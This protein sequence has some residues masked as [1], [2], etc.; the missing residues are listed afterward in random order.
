MPDLDRD[1]IL[2]HLQGDEDTL[3]GGYPFSRCSDAVRQEIDPAA[4]TASFVIVT[5]GKDVN[6]N[7]HRVQIT[8]SDDGGGFLLDSFGQNPVVFFD[9]GF[10]GVPWPIGR[11]DTPKLSASKATASVTFSQSLPEARV[12]FGLLDEG[13]LNTASVSFLPLKGRLFKP[14]RQKLGEDEFDFRR[15]Q[16]FDFLTNDLLE[17]SVVGVPADPGAVRK[18]LDRGQVGG[19]RITRQ[20]QAALAV[21]AERP[22]VYLPVVDWAG[23]AQQIASPSPPTA[24]ATLTLADTSLITNAVKDAVHDALAPLVSRQDDFARQLKLATGKVD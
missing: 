22:K 19:E 21:Y 11:S 8:A 14:A 6:R 15:D 23:L 2:Q 24:A 13:I 10:H 1:E 17:W 20:M 18:A 16:A 9:H 7:G 12:V 4:M 3:P 5:R